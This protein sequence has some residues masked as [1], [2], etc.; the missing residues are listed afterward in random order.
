MID[1]LFNDIVLAQAL[2]IEVKSWADGRVEL[3]AP[4]APN[5][6]DK[7]TAFAGSVSSILTLAGWAAITLSLK[8]CGIDADVM[9]VTSETTYTAALRGDLHAE[10]TITPGEVDRLV[11]ELNAHGRSRI[12]IDS[13][14]P[15][16]A[17]L[18]ASYAVILGAPA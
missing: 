8:E 13:M 17:T 1:S 14:I 11:N 4:L 3:T 12:G 5:L 16:F 10:A 18:S 7:G 9:V 15:G 6:N 2:G